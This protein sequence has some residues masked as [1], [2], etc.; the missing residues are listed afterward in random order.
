[1]SDELLLRIEDAAK[2]LSMGRSKTYELVARGALPS[3]LIGRSRRV[4]LTAFER[5]VEKQLASAEAEANGTA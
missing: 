2:R 4:P 1:M 3:L 5:C